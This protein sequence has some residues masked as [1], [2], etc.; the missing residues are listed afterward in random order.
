MLYTE[1]L[2]MSVAFRLKDIQ[3][4]WLTVSILSPFLVKLLHSFQRLNELHHLLPLA[5]Q[6]ELPV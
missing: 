3:L 2:N 1:P 6:N 5:V 4:K